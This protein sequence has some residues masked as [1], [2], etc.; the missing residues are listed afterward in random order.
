MRVFISWSLMWRITVLAPM[1]TVWWMITLVCSNE[2]LNR[3]SP[4][5]N[6]WKVV[7]CVCAICSA[8]RVLFKVLIGSYTSVGWTRDWIDS[9]CHHRDYNLCNN[10]WR[11]TTCH[12]QLANWLLI[13]VTKPARINHVS[14][15]YTKL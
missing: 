4:K 1:L 7:Y 15:N 10:L 8:I 3:A 11:F 9:S 5:Q 6:N 12:N 13:I 14:T 2:E